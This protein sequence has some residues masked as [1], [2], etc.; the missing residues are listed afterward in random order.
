VASVNQLVPHGVPGRE[1]ICQEM[2]LA[3][4][5][6]ESDVRERVGEFVAR[7]RRQNPLRNISL[8]YGTI[9]ARLIG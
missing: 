3:I 6:G 7:H 5:A 8:D 9:G 1:D 4:C 2:L